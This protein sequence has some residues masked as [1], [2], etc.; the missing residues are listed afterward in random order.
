[1]LN[2]DPVSK[3]YSLSSRTLDAGCRYLESHPLLDRANPFL[4]EL[5]RNAGETVNLAEPAGQDMIYIGRFPSLCGYW[6]TCPWAGVSPC[7]VPRP[8]ACTSPA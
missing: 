4:L 5:N 7:T 3:R 8:G 2:K 6:C 1:M